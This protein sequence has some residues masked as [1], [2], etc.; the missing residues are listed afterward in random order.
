MQSASAQARRLGGL[1]YQEVT[2]SLTTFDVTW[3][4]RPDAGVLSVLDAKGQNAYGIIRYPTTPTALAELS[5]ISNPPEA[6][7]QHSVEYRQTAAQAVATAIVRFL[8]TPD[9]GTGFVGKARTF[10]P[11]SETG[12]PEGCVDPPLQ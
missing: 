11:Q 4:R 12:S 1:I 8:T 9:P 5:Y 2:S 10:N 7:L 6:L 3:S